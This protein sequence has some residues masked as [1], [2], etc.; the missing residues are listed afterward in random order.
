VIESISLHNWKSHEDTHFRFG[1]GTNILVGPMGSGKS[2]V[3][4]ALCFALFGSFPALQHKRIKLSE[5]IMNRPA[6]KDEA[7]VKVEFTWQGSRYE[8]ERS[9]S[10]EGSS[11]ARVSREGK[12]IQGPQPQ[13]VTEEV[14]RLLKIDYEL[15]ARAVYSEQNR[16]DYFL[17]LGKGERKK[18]IDELLGISKFEVMRSN[19]STVLNRIKGMR[20]DKGALLGSADIEKLRKDEELVATELKKLDEGASA[21]L[22]KAKEAGT[23]RKD[24]EHVLSRMIAVEKFYM[25]LS[26]RKGAVERTVEN[27]E[28]EV[29]GKIGGIAPADIERASEDELAKLENKLAD[30]KK[31]VDSYT[32]EVGSAHERIRAIGEEVAERSALEKNAAE[33]GKNSSELEKERRGQEKE[34][35][36]ARGEIECSKRRVCELDEV[37]GEL[38]KELTKCP[39]CETPLGEEKRGELLGRRKNERKAELEKIEGFGKVAVEKEKLLDEIAGKVKALDSINERLKKLRGAAE[40]EKSN[41]SLCETEEKLREIA[42]KVRGFETEREKLKSSLEIKKSRMHI[43]KLKEEGAEVAKK[44]NEVKFDRAALDAKRVEVRELSVEERGLLER[45]DGM[46]NEMRRVEELIKEKKSERE[47][48]E[49]L[50]EEI[51]RYGAL[52]ENL[53]VFQNSVMETQAELRGELIGAINSAMKEMWTTIYPYRD[54]QDVRLNA[55]EDDYELQL[56]TGGD[57]V[58]VDGIASGGERS[59]ASI[60]MRMAFAMVLVPNLSWLILDEPTHNLDEEGMRALGKVLNEYIP[61]IVEQVFV[62]THDDSLK[63]AAS[64]MIYHLW[65]DKKDNGPTRVES[66]NV[67]NTALPIN[68]R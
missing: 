40:L 18:E 43:E 61:R 37:I 50:E 41:S 58:S 45:V 3:L 14:E 64:A 13:R 38:G 59:S 22:T 51:K 8:V 23:K 10:S 46:R 7:W 63:D 12:L 60:A 31:V 66:A 35:N 29:A 19:I 39:V 56:K 55:S 62:I 4:D 44:L 33:F 32:K 54:Y 11:E 42:E 27:L 15:F 68:T 48:Y 5:I 67:L 6:K 28:R 47:K 21:L 65:R 1:K 26:E 57:W 53:T 2:T 49:K 30:G 52:Y 20:E 25:E 34:L 36:G 24:A 17:M 9:I 16:M